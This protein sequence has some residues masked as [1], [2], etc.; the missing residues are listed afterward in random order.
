VS[1]PCQNADIFFAIRGGGGGTFGVVTEVVLKTYPT[2]RTTQHTFALS[3]LPNTT[4]TDFWST[5]GSLHAEM[6]RLKEG[7]MQGFYYIVGPPA[8]PSLAF[9]WSFMLFDKPNG[10]V[11]TLTAPISAYLMERANLFAYTS[12]ITHYD[13]YFAVA[14]RFDNEAVANGGSTYGSRLMSPQS[15]ADPAVNAEVLKSVGPSGNA[16]APNGPTWNPTII[17]HMVGSPNLPEYYPQ[18]S[19]LNPAWRDTLVH[20]VVVQGWQDGAHQTVIDAVRADVTSKTQKLREVSP[21]TGA[22]FNEADSNE[23]DWQESFFGKNYE[24][25]REIKEKVDQGHVL[26]CRKCVGSED[27]EE[28]EGGELCRARSVDHKRVEDRG[29]AAGDKSELKP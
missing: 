4:E 10:T 22:Y 6:Q 5:I 17:G 26:W 16:S 23:V 21:D 19:S 3:S 27:W 15:L 24:K 18:V 9:L 20:L 14:Q 29:N 12:N 8:Y 2:P 7:G 28:R 25:L 1:N 13:T 11:E